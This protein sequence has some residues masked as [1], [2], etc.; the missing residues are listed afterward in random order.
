MYRKSVTEIMYVV[1][2]SGVK[3]PKGGVFLRGKGYRGRG[4]V[5][6]K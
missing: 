6:L 1:I 5:C 4:K 3:K 2:V